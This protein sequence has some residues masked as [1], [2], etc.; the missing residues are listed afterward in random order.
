M[1]LEP[2]E[3]TLVSAAEWGQG[4]AP[5]ALSWSSVEL[6]RPAERTYLAARGQ[7]CLS[8]PFSLALRRN[9]YL[10]WQNLVGWHCLDQ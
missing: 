9:N 3:R 4:E 7:G 2:Q 8:P 6:W 10:G 5:D 1:S